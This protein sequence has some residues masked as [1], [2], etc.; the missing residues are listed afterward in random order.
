[1]HNVIYFGL[2]LD[3]QIAEFSELFLKSFEFSY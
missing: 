1:M 3:R 2:E